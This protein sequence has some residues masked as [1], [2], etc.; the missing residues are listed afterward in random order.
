MDRGTPRAMIRDGV[1]HDATTGC[2]KV[3]HPEGHGSTRP[4]RPARAAEHLRP[5]LRM[6]TRCGTAS[7]KRYSVRE[8]NISG[9]ERGEIEIGQRISHGIV[10]PLRS[11]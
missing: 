8:A 5:P 7:A 9:R 11:Q 2:G 10:S 1:R 6:A 4:P 3:Y